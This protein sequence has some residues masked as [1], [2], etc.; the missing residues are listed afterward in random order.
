MSRR[1]T[2]KSCR[3]EIGDSGTCR[4]VTLVTMWG[5]VTSRPP[6]GGK[7]GVEQHGIDANQRCRSAMPIRRSRR[8]SCR[9]CPWHAQHF[10]DSKSAMATL[11]GFGSAA[12]PI[13]SLDFLGYGP[14]PPIFTGAPS[15]GTDLTSSK[16]PCCSL[17]PPLRCSPTIAYC[18]LKTA[19]T[20]PS[21]PRTANLQTNV[22]KTRS[23]KRGNRRGLNCPA[24]KSGEVGRLSE[25]GRHG[26]EARDTARTPRRPQPTQ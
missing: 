26:P 23:A 22:A 24:K 15:T 2:F 19:S 25:Q 7:L 11:T 14:R 21:K 12:L 4:D 18:S 16:S 10:L 1:E 9:L 8:A 5:G 3:G 13:K 6:S 20:K 17:R